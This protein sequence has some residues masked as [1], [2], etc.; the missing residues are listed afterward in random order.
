MTLIELVT[1]LR[2]ILDDTGGHGV[3]FVTA[4]DSQLKWTNAELVAYINEAQKEVVRRTKSIFDSTTPEVCE[5]EIL[6]GIDEY[7]LHDSI[8]K[9]TRAK[10]ASATKN[11]RIV[12]YKDMD[13]LNSNW[14]SVPAGTIEYL[15]DDWSTN[16]IKLHRTPAADDVLNL[17]VC[18]LPLCNM[19]W[20]RRETDKPEIS[21]Q[22]HLAMLHWAAH[23]AY[24]KDE[25][26][27]LDPQAAERHD[28]K[29]TK[30]FGPK[31]DFYSQERRKKTKR[32]VSYGGIR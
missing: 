11:I 18:R 13:S 10:L 8:L 16:K 3:D 23:I 5:I 6:T 29:F 9:I 2:Y 15:I 28:I 26:N 19:V 27:T 24:F 25:P 14:E 20:A 1:Q 31:T 17:R 32:S 12:S 21:E 7:T 30:E 4:S 22:M